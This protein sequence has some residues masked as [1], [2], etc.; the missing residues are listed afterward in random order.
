M[1]VFTPRSGKLRFSGFWEFDV[2]KADA[3]M[4]VCALV[5]GLKPPKSCYRDGRFPSL[6]IV[7]KQQ[8][9]QQTTAGRLLAQ[10]AKSEGSASIWLT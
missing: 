1:A 6:R 4:N 3:I 7:Q 2:R 8:Q 9:A 5:A 10:V